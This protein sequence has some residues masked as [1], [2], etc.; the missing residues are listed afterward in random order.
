MSEETLASEVTR[1]FECMLV[2]I[3]S[4]RQNLGE[5]LCT[6]EEA[7]IQPAVLVL[8]EIWIYTHETAY[9]NISGYRGYFTCQDNNVAGGVAVF[10][11]E[12][13]SSY[14][15]SSYTSNAEVCNVH[16][17]VEG[18]WLRVTGVYRSP[19]SQYSDIDTFLEHDL[20]KILSGGKGG[21]PDRLWMGDINIDIAKCHTKT[22]LYL[23]RL[24]EYGYEWVETG[25]TRTSHD[26]ATATTVDHVFIRMTNIVNCSSEVVKLVDC[27]DHDIIYVKL[28]IQQH[29]PEIHNEAA[30][31]NW[32]K[33]DKLIKEQ[34]YRLYFEQSE[35]AAAAGLLYKMIEVCKTA[36]TTNT[37]KKPKTK[38]MKPW[39]TSEI[40]RGIKIRNR[41]R[42]QC[43]KYPDMIV[44]AER[45]RIYRNKLKG[46]IRKA[47]DD[48][49]KKSLGRADS[50]KKAWEVINR[51]IRGKQRKIIIPSVLKG[52][53]ERSKIELDNCASY[54]A[55][56]GMRLAES[57]GPIPD[58]EAI[59][60][61]KITTILTK[62]QHP[63]AGVIQ[64]AIK[65]LKNG[66][67]PG[68]DG[69][70]AE[71]L[72]KSPC[73]Y[74]DIMHHLIKLIFETGQYP[75]ELKRAAVVLIHKSGNPEHISNYRPISLLSV[76][77]KLIEQIITEQLK[78]H[79]Q[80]NGLLLE[81]QFGFRSGRGTQQALSCLQE[82]VQEALDNKEH[83]VAVFLDYS[84]A[85][86]TVPVK[87]L[88]N[89]LKAMGI[90]GLA[91]Q[92]LTSYL[93]N[94]TQCIKV[95]S[96][97]SRELNVHY[98]VPQG[99]TIAPL[100]FV[101]YIN[102][103]LYS[104]EPFETRIG[105]A[106]D[107]CIIFRFK[108]KVCRGSIENTL[109]EIQKWSVVNGLVLNSNKSQYITFGYQVQR[110]REPLRLHH[111]NCSKRHVCQCKEIQNVKNVKY[112]GVIIDEKLTWKAH[113]EKMKPKLRAALCCIS[114]IRKSVTLPTIR[115][116]YSA[117]F[118]SHL[119]YGIL[120]YGA[121]FQSIVA[122]LETLQNICLRKILG[123]NS[124][125]TA[126][127]LYKR[128]NILPFQSLLIQT[129]LMHF[130]IR[131]AENAVQLRAQHRVRHKYASRAIAAES[132]EGPRTRLERTQRLFKY[133]YLAMLNNLPKNIKENTEHKVSARK[134]AIRNY[135]A[136][137]TAVQAAALLNC[138]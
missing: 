108:E 20:D 8:T 96:T 137:L 94:R 42:G 67:A 118:E 124:R 131:E 76:I 133:R 120:A 98:G 112:L 45:Y 33:F 115:T 83:P 66:R 79:V 135:V 9:Y 22:D 48:Y 15:D 78:A 52:T 125:E 41:L 46:I 43:M 132:I 103:L 121:A 28:E 40:L 80:S 88:I 82:I 50:P 113:I 29:N 99:G 86:D 68:W 75:S 110:F 35:P 27:L 71:V 89:K 1:S 101:A 4:L 19:S 60:Q 72:N 32:N 81:R 18:K 16:V 31:I 114:K 106:D 92:V 30:S 13:L 23:N 123:A 11:R 117:L 69:L 95:G 2:N 90:D 104:T 25:A 55:E 65:K 47:E 91:L 14:Q 56:A 130:N 12:D 73:F 87:R 59:P 58:S 6:L 64:T 39:I 100:L 119:R 134:K 127:P 97:L 63:D 84:R 21:P 105:Y 128:A 62:F 7:H 136:G 116:I 54:F 138:N 34:D 93:Q 36:A 53:D 61:Y 111:D 109:K 57:N 74:A 26:K 102:D 85:F 44:L 107:T 126:S 129:I 51:D 17:K 37:S 5:L 10:I 38:P 70:T 24:A 49:I 77:N 3:R 122:D